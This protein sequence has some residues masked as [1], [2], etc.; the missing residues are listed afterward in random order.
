MKSST[1]ISLGLLV[2]RVGVGAMMLLGHGWAKLAGFGTLSDSFPDPLGIGSTASLVLAITAE[3][4]CSLLLILGLG[5]RFAAIPLLVTMLVAAFV[6]HG[7]DP[8]AK[9]ELALLYAVPFLTLILTG[10]GSWA[11]DS[12]L[13]IR[14]KR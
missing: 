11:L 13:E 10:G 2:L 8:W 6:V 1:M 4:L 5:T 7:G 9:K 3:A 12:V 14:R